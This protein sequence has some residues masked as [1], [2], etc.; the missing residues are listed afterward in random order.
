M[1]IFDPMWFVSLD[2]SFSWLLVLF[3]SCLFTTE[4]T[5]FLLIGNIFSFI[6]QVEWGT[7]QFD[8]IKK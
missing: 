1:Q 5:Y 4:K 7:D 3:S 6:R 2:W 8:Q